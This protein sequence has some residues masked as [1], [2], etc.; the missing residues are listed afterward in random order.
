MDNG[1]FIFLDFIVYI[2]LLL[3]GGCISGLTTGL[4]GVGGGTILSPLQYYLLLSIGV[5]SDI[6]L[7]MAFATSLGVLIVT[8][9]NATR[10]NYRNNIIEFRHL[11]ELI[12]SG[13]IGALIGSFINVNSET[14]IIS[15]IFGVFCI[16]SA[17]NMAFAKSQETDKN[18]C[19]S[20]SS[21]IILGSIVGVLSGLLG[22]GGAALMIPALTV[23]FKYPTHKA[24]GTS[25]AVI[26][27]ISVGGLLAY[28]IQGLNVVGL[29]E[30]SF[31]YLNL[32]QFVILAITSSI[33]V[34]YSARLSVRINGRILK[35]CQ[36]ILIGSMGILML[37]NPISVIF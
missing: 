25:S 19:G 9:I 2:I 16:L 20:K 13:F 10:E 31:G 34:T 23:I 29:P 37:M 22:V 1:R 35:I 5:D 32:I 24:I 3:I 36:I 11:K 30:Y 15:I 26:L 33:V 7:T 17:I 28:I 14:S 18:I 21:Y 12:A 27:I 8:F 4:I 6:A